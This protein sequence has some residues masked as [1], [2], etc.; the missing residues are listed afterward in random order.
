MP[1]D[2]D[3]KPLQVLCIGRVDPNHEKLWQQL[4]VEG[5]GLAFA[6][7]QRAGL[8]LARDLKPLVVVINTS[9]GAF[10]G[11]RLCR[12]LGRN[13]PNVQ[14]LLLADG[15]TGTKTSC[16]RRLVRPFTVARLRETV[17]ALLEAA[18][19]H[20]LR[21][22]SLQLNLATRIVMGPRGQQRLT[23]KQCGLLTYLMHRPNQV[24]SRQQL[25]K[26]VWETPYVDDTRTLDVHIRWLREHI[27]VDPQKPLMLVTRR[28]VGYMLV[29]PELQ[30][31]SDGLD[32]EFE[33]D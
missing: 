25:M 21:V 24:F 7:T 27:E 18:D 33:S 16:E 22:G 17:L 29:V 12:A 31:N 19:P 13:L 20:I 11:D 14:R 8:Q 9:N 4:Q 32:G 3:E 1:R 23:P 30:L 28:G 6:R 2:S 10:T 15:N 26:D 5:V